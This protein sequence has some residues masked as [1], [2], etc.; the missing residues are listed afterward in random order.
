MKHAPWIVALVPLF[1]IGLFA[2]LDSPA[3]SS[4]HE[5]PASKPKSETTSRSPRNVKST[6]A[7]EIY[8]EHF[9]KTSKLREEGENALA[10]VA[11]GISP[12]MQEVLLDTNMRAREASY[13]PLLESWNL[14]STEIDLAM[15]LVRDRETQLLQARLE[16]LK[17]GVAGADEF[18]MSAK[19]EQ[20]QLQLPLLG[21]LGERR[22]DEFVKFEKR[23]ES[24]RLAQAPAE[25]RQAV[26]K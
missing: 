13:R 22:Y 14:S 6:Q 11:R 10:R 7:D 17:T 19:S 9:K 2:L 16:F 24:E 20:A 3:P 4:S 15:K 25:I 18:R 26:R 23:F 12:G 1:M 5:R 21:L 8:S